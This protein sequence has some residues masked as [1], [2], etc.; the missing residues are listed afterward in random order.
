MS[1]ISKQEMVGLIY[2]FAAQNP[3]YRASLLSNPKALLEKQMQQSLPASLNVKVVQETA[4][5]LYL[6]APYVASTG[7]ELSDE[8]L[9][10]VA[11]GKGKGGG[12]GETRNE[13]E[14]LY[15]CND[16]TGVGTRVEIT[17]NL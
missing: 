3:D 7:D 17:T 14:N 13:T 16:A 15:I 5:T 9:E 8:D 6:I 1:E 11:G 10:K 12:G 2:R 4:D